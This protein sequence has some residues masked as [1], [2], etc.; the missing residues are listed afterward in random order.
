MPISLD[1][2]GNHLHQMIERNIANSEEYALYRKQHEWLFFPQYFAEEKRF[3]FNDRYS[4]ISQVYNNIYGYPHASD[5]SVYNAQG[6]LIY[7]FKKIREADFLSYLEHQN[8]H[9]YLIFHPDLYGYSVLDLTTA[10]DYHYYP[11]NGLY[12]DASFEE[13][14]IWAEAHYNKINNVLAVTGCIWAAPYDT[15]LVD[16]TEPLDQLKSQVFLHEYLDPNDDRLNNV[17]FEAWDNT[18]LNLQVLD[19]DDKTSR[20]T[21]TEAEY[22]R[23]LASPT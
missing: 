6:Q 21:L 13:T 3:M 19:V 14:F 7:T 11:E 16:F 22:Q 12:G 10:K 15:M 9:E 2:R 23:L 20:L 17:D 5:N 4:V 8:G 1:K 18:D